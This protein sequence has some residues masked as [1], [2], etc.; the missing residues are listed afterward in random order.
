MLAA[1]TV[2][3]A[4]IRTQK[5]KTKLLGEIKIHK[6]LKH[7][8]IVKFI[9]CF[10]DD[11]NVYILLEMCSNNSLMN[12]LR[13]RKMLTEPEAKYFLTQIIGGVQYMHDFG[14]IH[15]D[16]KLGNIFLDENM[17]V[18]IGDFGLAALLT[19]DSERKKTICGTPN[20]I[21]PEVLYGKEQG[22]S[23]EVD[24]WSL[25][26]IL[27]AMI[28]GKPPFQSKDVDTIYQRIKRNDYSFPTQGIS[29]ESQDL[30]TS[31]LH[32][33]PAQRPKLDKALSHQFFKSQFP[34]FLSTSCLTREPTF[35]SLTA[36]ESNVN[37][38]NCKVES[39][40][41]MRNAGTKELKPEA[42]SRLSKEE[43]SAKAILPESL[44]P[45]STKEKY[46][47]VMVQKEEIN[48]YRHKLNFVAGQN[49]ENAAGAKPAERASLGRAR[50]TNT[51]S[52]EEN[53]A[54]TAIQNNARRLK[55]AS[56]S[57]M[58][59]P[60]KT[61]KIAEKKKP[62]E[63]FFVKSDTNPSKTSCFEAASNVIVETMNLLETTFT[64][65]GGPRDPHV[66]DNYFP[67][68]QF[69]TKWVDYSNKYGIAYQ[70]SDGMVGVLFTDSST[71]Q[72]D[73]RVDSFDNIRWSTSN[74][75]W[76]VHRTSDTSKCLPSQTKRFRLVKT[77]YSYMQKNLRES[78]DQ[79][80]V[81]CVN[82]GKR[83]PLNLKNTIVFLVQYVRLG[84]V[85]MFQLSNGNFQFNFPDHTKL[86]LT[87]DG[88]TIGFIDSERNLH[89]WSM[90]E[91][92]VCCQP[93]LSQ[94]TDVMKEDILGKLEHCLKSLVEIR[95]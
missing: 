77:M 76:V 86:I 8:N 30:I 75:Q 28:V 82:P 40:L 56:L 11:V 34:A 74:K 25:G 35:P 23:Y 31:F 47:M 21:A 62:E 15:R 10:E 88:Q 64:S 6:V 73:P 70:F 43:A 85:V 13:K 61:E 60:A 80:T 2:A 78:S 68:V 95:N 83:D 57:V 89:C 16:L 42:I 53:F 55:L 39:R 5:T 67:T 46:K 17:T 29:L 91:G 26:I 45:A 63:N 50:R 7:P 4:S 41:M 24:I 87:S 84:Q 48:P 37:F 59:Q 14:V 52:L 36:E 92:S 93:F 19:N 18:K 66:D 58:N 9:D 3:K 69:V 79:S 72:L 81:P 94:I 20:Y 32:N 33:D 22:H 1:K 65:S 90:R 12:M 49:A 44:S 38:V 54:K 51:A 27:Y 71:T